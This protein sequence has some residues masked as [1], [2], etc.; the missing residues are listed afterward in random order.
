MLEVISELSYWHWIVVG[1]VFVIIEM[2]VPGAFF[3]GMGLASLIVG[4]V[5]W[6]FPE[7]SWQ[8][9]FFSFAV[10]AFV[11]ILVSRHWIKSRPIV[12][13][14]PLLNQRGT[15]Y[16]GRTFTLI[17]DMDNGRSKIQVDDTTWR[18]Q[19]EAGQAGEN[20]RVTGID[21]VML[22]VERITN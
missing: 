15:Q 7:F 19:G 16:I 20:V 11:S 1:L 14:Q 18:V 5:L 12:S 21:G 2:F 8:L 3:F 4:S 10:L 17:E 13:D 6:V 9:Q 22:Q